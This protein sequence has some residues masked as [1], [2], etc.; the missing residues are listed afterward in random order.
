MVKSRQMTLALAGNPNSGKTTVF[1]NLTGARQHVGNWPGK[2]VEKKEGRFTF[3]GQEIQVVDLPGAYSLGAYS[4]DEIIARDYILLEDPDAVI[5]V[6]D[7]T[8]LDRN[9]YMTVQMLEMGARVV[10][11]LNMY[12][13]V[14]SRDIKIDLPELAKRLCLPVLATIA[15]RKEGMKELVAA[16]LHHSGNGCG[17]PLKI[18]YG[19]VAEA[20][21][22]AL[23]QQLQTLPTLAAKFNPRWLA[24]KL[25]EGDENIVQVMGKYADVSPLVSLAADASAHL[26]ETTG[27]DAASLFAAKRYEYIS[28]VLDKVVVRPPEAAEKLS[29]SDRIDRVVT[30]RVWGIPIFLLAMLAVFQFTFAV[31]GVFTGW[32]ESLFEWFGGAVSA[33]LASIS[34]PA[35]LV[36]LTVDG[37]ISGVG[38]VLVF[39]PNILLLFLAISI[40]EDSGYLARAAYIMDRFMHSLGLHGKS[41]IPLILGFGCNVPAIMATRTLANRNDRLITILINPLMSCTARL[42]VYVLFTGALFSAYQGIVIFSLYVLGLFLAILVGVLLKKIFFK[43]EISHFVMELPPY[44]VPTLRSTVTNMW[45]R[46]SSFIRKAGTIIVVAVILVWVLASL[47]WGVAYASETS[48][49]GRLGSFF[50]PIFAPAGFGNWEAS[51]A[52]IFGVVAKE[53]VVGTLGVVYGAEGAGLTTAIAQS[54]LPLSAFAFM[55]MTLVYI[56]CVATIGAIKKETNSWRWTAFAV[57]YSLVLGWV[58]AVAIYQIGRLIGLG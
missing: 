2:T 36:S 42:P 12:D 1:N 20:E 44:R 45:D 28:K 52:L 24:I 57:G 18:G 8:N 13:E 32:V 40:M 46:S 39:L 58:V 21:I 33:G 23:S 37:I 47:P 25:L 3:D 17:A 14:Q 53:I 48:I 35:I 9:L 56:P 5:N 26:E 19:A 7:A 38:S 29:L 4:E 16:A 34:A 51:V 15:T 30:H 43:G 11:A 55:A 54:W 10:L 6:I 50:T 22:S 31:G 41:F 27:E 49:L